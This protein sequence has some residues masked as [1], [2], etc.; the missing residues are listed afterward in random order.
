MPQ[1]LKLISAGAGSGKTYRLTEEMTALL[2][3][4]TARPSGIIATT[5]TKKAAAELRERVRVKLLREGMSREANELKNALI[6]TVHGLGVKLLRRFAFEAG[7]SPQVDIIAEEDHQRLFNLSMAA[8]I[9]LETIEEIETLCDKLGLSRDGEKFNWRKEVLRLVEIIRGNNFSAATIARSKANSW[10]SL[11]ELLPPV[12][13][14]LTAESFTSRLKIAL[15]ETIAAL[16]GNEEVD[17]TKKTATA[18]SYLRRLSGQLQRRGYLPWHELCKLARFEKEVGA[19]SRE[20]VD[21]IVDIGL[22][23][24]TTAA[25]QNDLHRY[26]D[27]LFDAAEASIAEY[28]RY[29]K[30]RGRIDYTDMEVL[31]LDLLDHPGVK[32]T[33]ERELDLLMVDEFQ[34][35]SPIQLA[36]F[37]KLS[38]LARQSVWVG[39]PKQSIYGFRGAEPR[40]MKAVMEASGPMDPANIQ[41]NSWR[42]REDIVYACNALFTKAFPEI[43]EPAVVLEPVRLRSGSSFA[44]AESAQMAERSG[45]LHWHFELEG[46]ARYA[47]SWNQAVVAKAVRELLDSPPPCRPK[48]S[49][50]ERSLLPGDIAILC[51]SNYGCVAMAEALAAQGLPAAIARTGLLDTAEAHLLLACLKYMLNRQDSLSVAEILLF[52]QRYGLPDIIEKRLDWLEYYDTLSPEEKR[53]AIRWGHDEVLIKSLNELR[54]ATYEHST[55]EMINLLLERLDLRRI[56]V[57]WGDGEQRL[58]NIDELRRLATAYEDNCHRQHRAA[59]LGG[60]LLYLDE[61]LRG[62]RD[63]QGASERMD[64]VNV[65]T[66]HRS[67]GLEWPA[68]VAMDLDQKLRADVWGITIVSETE[69]VDLDQPLAGRW[70]KYWV[71]P[72]GKLTSGV[73][74]LEAL[75]ESMW[76]D[77]ATEE[78]MAEEARLLYV[79]FTRARD[80]LILPTAKTGAPWL[81]RAF[82]RGGGIIPVLDPNSSD[83]PFDWAGHE[84]TKYTQ[85]WTEP[86]NLPSGELSHQPV[87]FLE[88]PRAGRQTIEPATVTE[89]WLLQTFGDSNAAAPFSYYIP[90]ALEPSID[91]RLYGQAVSRFLQGDWSMTDEELR[92]E[93]ATTLLAS[94]LPG[95]EIDVKSLIQQSTVFKDWLSA[96]Y[97]MEVARQV[98]LSTIF[99]NR[100]FQRSVD[101]LVTTS[102]NTYVLLMD[103]QHVSRQFDLQ[104]PLYL[105]ELSALSAAVEQVM[106]GKVTDAYLHL[107]AIGVVIQ[108]IPSLQ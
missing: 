13:E 96:K 51:R 92:K 73:P 37:L 4:G 100:S 11:A 46:K 88:G 95:E 3:A 82:S 60:Y 81:D 34:D 108:A 79:G 16:R 101:W 70:L 58:S 57:A 10:S 99:D 67:K 65:L 104:R 44:P 64:A 1:N 77:S 38:K 22:A 72:Y 6:G 56:I 9:S 85:T 53:K 84:V 41:K 33:L 47:K 48:G 55:S 62:Q 17:G 105:A 80:Y 40:L 107:P 83:A 14:R 49:E 78:A 36:V 66:Y 98:P 52:G 93:R 97:G 24:T 87:P 25:F 27:L 89:P 71:N 42:S 68:V 86:R 32:A 50:E 54:A 7:V 8:V 45:I 29:K 2:T 28:D 63:Q 12:N 26:Q 91:D 5:F 39:D 30:S 69:E 20:F 90:P 35:T 21:I 61:L 43:P 106:G 76:Q 102:P 94:Y 23:H 59:S 19:K 103:I 15:T 74:W 75:S 18:I 31:V